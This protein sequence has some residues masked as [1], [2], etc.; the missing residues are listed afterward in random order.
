MA[1]RDMLMGVSKEAIVAAENAAAN[2]FLRAARAAAPVDSGQLR[3]SIKIIEGKDKSQLSVG[4]GEA[5]RRRLFVGPE[6]KKGYY[7]FF[8]EKGYKT[9]GPKRIKR[10]A[11]GNTHSQSGV[12]A[13]RQISAHSWFEPAMRSAEASATQAAESAFNAKLQELNGRK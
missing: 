11:S 2:V 1:L 3:S 4:V 7:G 6:K 9:A 13:R 8:V 12:A 10:T 5:G